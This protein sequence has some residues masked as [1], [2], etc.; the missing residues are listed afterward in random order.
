MMKYVCMGQKISK[1]GSSGRKKTLAEW[2]SGTQ[3]TWEIKLNPGDLKRLFEREERLE[4]KVQSEHCK[5]LKAE[6]E[7]CSSEVS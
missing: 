7:L 5:R 6:Q 1:A 3:S 2:R 4:E